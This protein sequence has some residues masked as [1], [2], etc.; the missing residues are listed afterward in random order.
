M[1]GGT[2]MIRTASSVI[3]GGRRLTKRARTMPDTIMSTEDGKTP[4]SQLGGASTPMLHVCTSCSGEC[5]E[6]DGHGG[7]QARE[8]VRYTALAGSTPAASA[9]RR[10][11][12]CT[13]RCARRTRWSQS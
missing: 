5:G 6:V 8:E 13:P 11:R 7:L 1:L 10:P 12:P 9:P 3:K 2:A 4:R